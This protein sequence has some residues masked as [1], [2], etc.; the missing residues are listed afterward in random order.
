MAWA[1][2]WATGL[3][4]AWASLISYYMEENRA[5]AGFGGFRISLKNRLALTYALFMCLG[6]GCLA[7]VINRY[8]GLF[9]TGLVKKN[10]ERTSAEI[11]RTVGEQYDPLNRLF[12]AATV[13]AIGM[14]FVHEGYILTVTDGAG[15]PVWNAR[16]CDMRQC[17]EVIGEITRRMEESFHLD[18]AMQTRVFPVSYANRVVG[19]VTIETYGPFFFSE[20]ERSFLTSVNRL[21]LSAAVVLILAGVVISTALASAIARPIRLAGDAARRIAQFYSGGRTGAPPPV[22]MRDSYR[23]RELAGLARSINELSRELDEAERRQ[24]RLTADIA[25]ELRT[26]LAC[27][28]GSIEAMIDGVYPPDAE[29]LA[30]CHEE[31]LRL[32][33]LVE[34]LHT[35]TSLEW[36]TITLSKTEFDLVALLTTVTGQFE[37]AAR[38]KGITITLQTPQTDRGG[39]GGVKY[40]DRGGVAIMVDGNTVTVADTGIGIPAEDLPHIFERFF[41]SDKSRSRTSGGSGIGLAVAAAIVRAHGGVISAES[42]PESGSV[43]R[44]QF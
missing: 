41:R 19:T 28:Q 25:H 40:T 18:G 14:Y 21:L 9:F 30:S 43:F 15:E 33:H 34:D 27:L 2:A 36:D 7:L 10:I 3:A 24:K 35:L 44:V 6:L 32:T 12:D 20:T 16:G 22:T 8:T 39:E 26:P 23:T 11:A 13:Q 1:T 5:P 29:R 17:M 4:T 37:N 31:I 38:E 42:V